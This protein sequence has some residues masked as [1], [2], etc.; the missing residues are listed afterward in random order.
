M[1]KWA[2]IVALMVRSS[3]VFTFCVGG[4][5]HATEESK[6]RK[7]LA[8]AVNFGFGSG[9]NLL[10]RHTHIPMQR[11]VLHEPLLSGAAVANKDQ[12]FSLFFTRASQL[13]YGLD[14]LVNLDVV[15]K[16]A[17][18]ALEMKFA[19]EDNDEESAYDEAIDTRATTIANTIEACAKQITFQEHR[20]GAALNKKWRYG[21]LYLAARTW[22]GLAE[23]NYWLDQQYRDRIT[24]AMKQIFPSNDGTFTMSDYVTMNW[25]IGDTHLKAGWVMPVPHNGKY[26]AGI[27]GII[28]TAN[29]G[30]RG[31]A[32]QI[33]PLRLDQFGTYART[34]LNEVLIS[35]RLG[36]GGHFGVGLWHD[37]SWS[38]KFYDDRHQLKLRGYAS[39]DYLFES[40]EERLLMRYVDKEV[41]A[42]RGDFKTG[43]DAKFRAFIG[44]FILPEPVDVVIAPGAILNAGL[45]ARYSVDKTRFLVGYDWYCK[46]IETVVRC[47]D[48]SDDL[49]YI[50]NQEL[51]PATKGIQ[52]KVFGAVS[53]AT[54]YSNVEVLGFKMNKL[55]ISFA[56]HG[57]ASLAAA[58]MGKDFA[59]GLSL[60]CKC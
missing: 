57:A 20:I 45:T 16:I 60:G 25:G 7:E 36:N 12:S 27:K 29:E 44:Q 24:T 14:D 54:Q 2:K 13:C 22:V 41:V 28:P 38:K 33:I 58:G 9:K 31:T 40:A 43:E 3:L 35:P 52:H 47:I 55:G 11:D 21:Q 59:V 39:A 49:V 51:V 50:P 34:R 42:A 1:K 17:E 10:W 15:Q 19:L 5:L 26:R 48:R 32:H 8:L 56:V 18:G 30:K 46:D 4:M 23:R 53:Y 6:Q 37:F